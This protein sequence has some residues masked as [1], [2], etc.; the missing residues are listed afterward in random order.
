MLC[1]VG[2]CSQGVACMC[3]FEQCLPLQCDVGR[4]VVEPHLLGANNRFINGQC[5]LG[6]DICKR[7]QLRLVLNTRKGVQDNSVS[8]LDGYNKS[9]IA[10]RD[11]SR[12][13]HVISIAHNGSHTRR[14]RFTWSSRMKQGWGWG[15]S[16]ISTSVSGFRLQLW[17]WS[18]TEVAG[19]YPNG[20]HGL[21]HIAPL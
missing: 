6:Q 1:L 12:W 3:R 2:I 15:A 8:S 5:R 18:R 13:F 17:C 4:G 16:Q 21:L 7:H 19:H 11:P 10:H 9:T 14:Q 20:S